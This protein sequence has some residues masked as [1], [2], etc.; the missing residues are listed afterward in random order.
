MAP[1]GLTSL[2]GSWQVEP[3]AGAG[4]QAGAGLPE[5]MILYGS[6]GVFS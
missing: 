3:G 5:K 2:P 4:P 6:C 1:T